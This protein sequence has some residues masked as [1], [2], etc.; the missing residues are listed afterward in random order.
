MIYN[1]PRQVNKEDIIKAFNRASIPFDKVVKSNL[2]GYYVYGCGMAR[3]YTKYAIVEQGQGY[4][5]KLRE[6]IPV[7]TCF[8]DNQ[9]LLEMAIAEAKMRLKYE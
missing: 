2:G 5:K 1:E 8:I 7:K 3:S 9:D 4:V 6:R